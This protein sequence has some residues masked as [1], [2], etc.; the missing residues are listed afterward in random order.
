MYIITGNNVCVCQ[1]E[2]PLFSPD[3]VLSLGVSYTRLICYM[4]GGA[5]Q[6]HPRKGTAICSGPEE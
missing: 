5:V 6:S 3:L 4:R 2:A 1:Y